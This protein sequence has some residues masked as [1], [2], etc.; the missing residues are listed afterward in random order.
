MNDEK[1]IEK[2]E[3][4]NISLASIPKRVGAFCVD[5]MVVSLLFMF[6]YSSQFENATT[7]EQT[8]NLTNNLI[9]QV[10]LLRIIYQSFFVWMY[11]ATLGK[12]LF[13][14]RVLSVDL[15]DNPNF[16]MSFIRAFVRIVSEL[17]M[18]LGFFWA[19]SNPKKETW[20]DKAA[21]TLVINA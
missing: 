16:V 11:G 19:F 18:Y 12:M 2:F 3:R 6:A 14:I 17:V 1:I 13:K 15:L 10:I 9:L 8:I 4:E 5:E 20:H 7:I 21:G